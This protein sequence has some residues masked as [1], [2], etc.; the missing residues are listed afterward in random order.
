MKKRFLVPLVATLTLSLSGC[1]TVLV[2]ATAAGIASANDSRTVGAQVDDQAIEIKAVATLKDDTRLKAARIQVVSFNRTVLLM[3]Q[4]EHERLRSYAAEQIRQVDGV[5][6][7]HNEIRVGEVIGLGQISKDSW[8]TS[9]VKTQLLA[10]ENVEGSRIKVVTENGEV[11]LL[12]LISADD[13]E[14]AVEIARNVNG[15]TRVIDAFE[16]R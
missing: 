9:K 6:R 7:V 14:T 15:V 16:V 4:V 5:V 13:A 8:I 12:G 11:F 1:A 10:S 2:G 3:G